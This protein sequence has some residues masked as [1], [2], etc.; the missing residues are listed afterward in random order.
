MWNYEETKMNLR[1]WNEKHA[2]ENGKNPKVCWGCQDYFLYAM[3]DG[4]IVRYT[5]GSAPTVE[6]E[7][8][9]KGRN[10]DFWLVEEKG[11]ITFYK[12]ENG[13]VKKVKEVFGT[14]VEDKRIRWD[15]EGNHPLFG[16]SEFMN[17]RIKHAEPPKQETLGEK[18]ETTKSRLIEYN[19]NF[20]STEE[21]RS[22]ILDNRE[23]YEGYIVRSSNGWDGD[24]L[25]LWKELDNGKIIWT[26]L[27]Y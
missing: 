9:Y 5:T 24:V 25:Y 11:V 2:L 4:Y 3:E 7:I 13:N 1:D 19:G 12:N 27:K 15:G 22:Y 14:I 21:V 8:Y 10:H 17:Y 26:K 23:D 20:N 18:S 16:Y 6:E